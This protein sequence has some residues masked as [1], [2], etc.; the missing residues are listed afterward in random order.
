MKGNPIAHIN[1]DEDISPSMHEW[2]GDKLIKIHAC[3]DP[4]RVFCG[5]TSKRAIDI[6]ELD[7]PLRSFP[8]ATGNSC[9]P[10]HLPIRLTATLRLSTLIK[11]QG[12]PQGNYCTRVYLSFIHSSNPKQRRRKKSKKPREIICR[13]E[14][15]LWLHQNYALNSII[16]RSRQT[17]VHWVFGSDIVC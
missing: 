7:E 13:S 15:S 14:A 17:K 10:S 4:E 12:R 2:R 11:A 8:S 9:A 6:R 3:Q 5:W 1:V 16:S